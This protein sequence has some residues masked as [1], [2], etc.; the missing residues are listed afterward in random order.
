MP[1]PTPT[2]NAWYIKD[3]ITGVILYYLPLGDDGCPVSEFTDWIPTGLGNGSLVLNDLKITK[4]DC[5]DTPEKCYEAFSCKFTNLI[6]KN[7]L[8]L[9]LDIASN[10]NHEMFGLKGCEE[11]WNNI[12]MRYLI[13]DV[14]EC[15][16]YGFYSESTENCLI[17]KLSENCNC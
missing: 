2:I 14:L 16:P 9:S 4:R 6:K 1:L 10:R 11:N 15:S 12:F 3:E 8:Q 13:M 17:N 5:Y 7:K